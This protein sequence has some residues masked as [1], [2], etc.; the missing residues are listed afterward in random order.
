M[1]NKN[2]PLRFAYLYYEERI[3]G[4]MKGCVLQ[5]QGK[6]GELESE[7][8]ELDLDNPVYLKIAMCMAQL[9]LESCISE[10]HEFLTVAPDG[11]KITLPFAAK[12]IGKFADAI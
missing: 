11:A 6:S 12:V 8:L 4:C 1:D 2:T 7:E 3:N 9:C 10:G 5:D